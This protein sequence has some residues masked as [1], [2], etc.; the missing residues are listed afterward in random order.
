MLIKWDGIAIREI[1]GYIF[2][3]GQVI[4]VADEET[5]LDILTQPG[6]PFVE[7]DQKS[8]KPA[9]AARRKPAKQED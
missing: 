8:A 2:Q 1:H 3:P 4:E 9:Q 5:A 7:I 6:E